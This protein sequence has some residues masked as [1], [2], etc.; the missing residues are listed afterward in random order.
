M[1]RILITGIICAATSGLYA[2]EAGI[3]TAKAPK[4]TVKHGY[5]IFFDKKSPAL[6]HEVVKDSTRYSYHKAPGFSFGLTFARF[7]LGLATL[8]DNGSFTLSPQ[9]QFLSYRSWK[10]SNVGFDVVQTGYRFSSAFKIYVAGG[11]DWTLIRLRQN[12]TIQR[13][14]P[15]LTYTTDN[16]N[17]SKNRFSA[18]YFRVPLAF[19]FRT[20]DDHGG[21]AYHFVF[22]PE[23]GVLLDGRVKQ[24]SDQNG[25]QKIDGG[26][27]FAKYRY[28]AVGRVGHGA[29]GIF[30]KYYFNDMFQDSPAQQGLKDF[31]FGFTLGF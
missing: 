6:E 25:K 29:F 18:S 23:F 31:A 13:G 10:T 28:G 30:A 5:H 3:D 11:F 27:H 4:D 19:D 14:T 15:T 22:G 17:Y 2:H 7:D 9:N 8:V 26:Y 16:I 20:H 12:I 21:A 24:I 1:K